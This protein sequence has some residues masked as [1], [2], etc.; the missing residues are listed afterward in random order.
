[1][2]FRLDKENK[3][4][5]CSEEKYADDCLFTNDKIERDFTGQLVFATDKQ[6][7]EYKKAFLKFCENQEKEK[8]RVKRNDECFSIINRGK[9]WYNTLTA[10]QLL[11]LENWYKLWLDV[12]QS[13]IEPK[14]PEF[15]CDKSKE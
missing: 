4:I 6:T 12:T 8:L 1:M 7:D 11:E 10:E 9:L 13:K 15:L 2:F 5:D 14:K 3:I